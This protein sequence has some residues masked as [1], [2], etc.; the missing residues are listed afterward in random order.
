MK[1]AYYRLCIAQPIDWLRANLINPNPYQRPIHLALI[2]LA[3]RN[4]EQHA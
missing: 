2:R 3:I 1:R 4:K